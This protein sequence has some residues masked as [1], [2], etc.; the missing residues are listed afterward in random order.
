[1]AKKEKAPKPPKA[2]KAPK[3]PKPMK[4]PP[5][6]RINYSNDVYTVLASIA[7]V[8]SLGTV[9]FAIYRSNELFGT[10]F[11]GFAG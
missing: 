5:G 2:P 3:A 1:M 6:P 11:P 9:S 8:I 4:A 7:L 10:P